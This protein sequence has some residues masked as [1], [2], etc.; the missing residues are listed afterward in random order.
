MEA[1][2]QLQQQVAER[3]DSRVPLLGALPAR[4][5]HRAGFLAVAERV[6]AGDFL[7]DDDVRALAARATPPVLM[8]LVELAQARDPLR[9]R[10][11]KV[12][13]VVLLEF[14][15]LLEAG[16]HR[17]ALEEARVRLEEARRAAPGELYAAIDRWTG[18]FDLH[19]LLALLRELFEGEQ[20]GSARLLGPSTAEVRSLLNQQSSR[21][22]SCSLPDLLDLLRGVGVNH[23]EGGSDLAIHREALALGFSVSIGTRLE[24]PTRVQAEGAGGN[25]APLCRTFVEELLAVRRDL[26]ASSKITCWFPWSLD[27]SGTQL[28]R[29][30]ALGRLALRSVP[31]I[32]AP[33]SLLGTKMAHAA[34]QFGAND[35]GF[36]A[37]D[38]K[39]ASLLEVVLLSELDFLNLEQTPAGE[40]A[41]EEGT[42]AMTD[43]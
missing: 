15:A 10:L 40:A 12:R 29:A 34:L 31:R 36:A 27:V 32:R 25:Q 2:H 22:K 8:K 5:L 17:Q 30:I 39:T 16:D 18:K 20:S 42:A 3:E 4:A 28:L 11:P 37:V 9:P 43:Q 13:P 21:D 33:L 6:A 26:S 35:I 38:G 23:V 14:A 41:L 7:T 19:K 24:E 1:M